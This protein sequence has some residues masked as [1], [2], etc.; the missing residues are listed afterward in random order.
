M[1]SQDFDNRMK[2]IFPP[3]LAPFEEMGFLNRP[4]KE[5]QKIAI[6][7]GLNKEM[8]RRAIEIKAD[9]LLVHNSL[10]DLS[11]NGYYQE[12][13][14][15]ADASRLSIYR[16]H[17]AMDFAKNG[18]IDNLCSLLKLKAIPT[19]LG[20]QDYQIK[21]GVYLASENLKFQEIIQRLQRINPKSIRIAGVIK[22]KY[23]KI[24]VTTGDGCYPEFLIQLK[25]DAFVCGLLNQESERIARDL[26]ITIF[27][28]TSYT[29]ENEP[30]K[31]VAKN[32]K[33]HFKGSLEIEFIDLADSIKVVKGGDY[34]D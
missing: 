8:I 14:Q 25:P 18:L 24:A 30:L 32:L 7:L 10:S 13:K 28:T 9:L 5:I 26:N 20:Y 27:E 22:K 34:D 23:Q 6:G 3:D 16:V 2:T 19:I 31:M 12:L 17:L 4:Q 15:L 11:A 33:E 29:T 1:N 21:G